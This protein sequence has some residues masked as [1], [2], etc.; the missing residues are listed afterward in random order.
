M[1]S[2]DAQH[3]TIRLDI[4][5]PTGAVV[6][7][8]DPPSAMNRLPLTLAPGRFLFVNPQPAASQS[9]PVQPAA[10]TSLG[11]ICASVCYSGSTLPT[12]VAAL[13]YPLAQFPPLTPTDLPVPAAA[14]AGTSSDGGYTWNWEGS[15]RVPGADHCGTGVGAANKLAV[16]KLASGTWTFDGSVLFYGQT[17]TSGPCCFGSG[18]STFAGAP[19]AEGKVYPA[20]WCVMG[21]GFGAGPLAVFNASWALRQ[22]RGAAQS[23]WDNG[24]DGSLAPAVRLTLDAHRGWELV[25]SFLATRVAYTLPF[26]GSTFGPLLFPGR[27][28][29]LPAFGPVTLPAI[30]V[31]A[32]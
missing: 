31:A 8:G 10:G 3:I 5:V 27:Q 23:A 19:L 15:S 32:M 24:A 9:W 20:V 21:G 14:V 16:W 11:T 13:V 2:P 4:Q 22:V 26:Q 29:T 25:L 12:S 7:T 30:H 1:S 17:C 6:A 28:E 18:L